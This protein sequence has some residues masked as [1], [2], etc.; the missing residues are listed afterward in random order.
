[1]KE[2]GLVSLVMPVWNKIDDIDKTLQSV[3]DQTWDSIELILVNDGATDGTRNRLDHW[4][5]KLIGRKI[6]CRIIDQENQG[7]AAAVKKGLHLIT[8]KYFTVVDCDD[9]LSPG[10]CKEKASFLD[11]NEEYGVCVGDFCRED[12][13][14]T[15]YYSAFDEKIEADLRPEA[16]LL[17]K[18]HFNVW[19]WLFRKEL[20][21]KHKILENFSDDRTGTHEIPILLPI[22]A[23]ETLKI[24]H[25]KEY[26]LCHNSFNYSSHLG[27]VSTV[28]KA[29][30]YYIPYCEALSRH[31]GL[32]EV[33]CRRKNRLLLLNEV[34][35]CKKILYDLGFESN[36]PRLKTCYEALLKRIIGLAEIPEGCS[37]AAMTS[38]A[39]YMLMGEEAELEKSDG[40]AHAGGRTI[41]YGALGTR[42]RAYLMDSGKK[43]MFDE[44]WDICGNDIEVSRP[45]FESLKPEDI[46]VVFPESSMVLDYIR[47]FSPRCRIVAG[48]EMELFM[49]QKTYRLLRDK[50]VETKEEGKEANQ[51]FNGSGELDGSI[52]E[53][54]NHPTNG[55]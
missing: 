6:D 22:L 24:G 51:L 43:K 34:F 33:D 2:Q 50:R 26:L 35:F 1:M 4:L 47:S 36:L 9:T 16:F 10:Y 27:S 3:Y 28:Q 31:I 12:E 54:L 30:G 5:P 20:L 18:L 11:R 29:L 21:A 13:K 17:S 25:I 44:L 49:A 14:G 32:L 7:M 52:F 23:D 41:A 38:V 39:Q 53:V 15:R 46:L 37:P 42:A 48:T 55:L 19:S 8:G 40:Q 45:A